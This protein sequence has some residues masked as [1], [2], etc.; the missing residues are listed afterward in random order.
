MSFSIINGQML[1]QLAQI[2]AWLLGK[3]M[4]VGV[5]SISVS[6]LPFLPAVTHVDINIEWKVPIVN[7]IKI[8]CEREL[9]P[10]RRQG[11][12]GA[13]P[14]GLAEGIHRHRGERGVMD[15][16][17][18]KICYYYRLYSTLL[19]ERLMIRELFV[20]GLYI[21]L[22]NNIKMYNLRNLQF[23]PGSVE[24]GLT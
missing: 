14:R 23:F 15:N 19:L 20:C 2:T 8:L 21:I 17:S 18:A 10:L 22:N 3:C 9:G 7:H 16:T 13:A 24:E 12:E 6:P 4:Y 11:G 1:L 5:S